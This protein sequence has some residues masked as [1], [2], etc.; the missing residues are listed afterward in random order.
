MSILNVESIAEYLRQTQRRRALLR[1]LEPNL[2][3]ALQQDCSKRIDECEREEAELAAQAKRRQEAALE[4][5]DQMRKEGITIS[6]LA[7]PVASATPNGHSRVKKEK[8][9]L[10]D[11]SIVMWSR[12]GKPPAELQPFVEQFGKAE[13]MKW[14]IED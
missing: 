7:A 5:L 9:R 11:G 6:D 1:A 8:F 13:V 2:L 4:I 14:I 3:K 10:P 12:R